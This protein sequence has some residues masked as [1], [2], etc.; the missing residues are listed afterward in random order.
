MGQLC[1][2]CGGQRSMVYCRSDSAC[3]C[4]SCDRNVHSA[5]ALSRRHSRTLLCEKCCSQPAT[6]RCLEEKTSLC[7][8]CDWNAHGAS[9]SSSPHKRQTIHC[10]SGC[11]SAAELSRIWSFVLNFPS[12]DDQS[13]CEQRTGLMSID[14]NVSSNCW[15][16]PGNT[17]MLDD[18]ASGEDD[19][20]DVDNVNRYDDRMG[21]SSMRVPSPIPSR[22]NQTA[23]FMESTKPKKD[24]SE[25]KRVGICEADYF[26]DFNASDMELNCENYDELFGVSQS[27]S[28]QLFENGGIDSLFGVKD[29]SVAASNCQGSL[30]GKGKVVQPICSDAVSVDSVMSA[31]TEPVHYCQEKRAHSSLSLS[32][33]GL[34]GE[35]SV[36][37]YQDCGVSSMLLMGDSSLDPLGAETTFQ[38]ASRDDAVMRYKEKKKSRKFEKKIRY[39]SRKARAD[40]RKRVKGR[41]VK[42]GDAYDYDPLYQTRTF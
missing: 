39:A 15:D 42:A 16:P 33:S 34:T 5:N 27:N 1:D 35:S 36:G 31:K 37:D 40:I 6:I 21:S 9:T 19:V 25:T 12:M 18:D 24:S 30:A 26:E 4:L 20:D 3:L 22:V 28:E 11:P 41:F 13:C 17:N 38:S 23:G 7:Q 2:F 32:F 29:L 8:N 10:Y 14:E